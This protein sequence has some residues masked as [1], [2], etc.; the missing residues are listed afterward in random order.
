MI[1]DQPDHK[2]YELFFS[3]PVEPGQSIDY[4]YIYNWPGTYDYTWKEWNM[5]FLFEAY[6]C[7]NFNALLQMPPECIPKEKSFKINTSGTKD[8]SCFLGEQKKTDPIIVRNER[9][10]NL[11]W[12]LKNVPTMM[13]IQLAWEYHLKY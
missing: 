6:P 5:R 12:R 4:W 11:L 8:Y 3:E 9:I 2:R 1:S 10:T 13:K 7:K